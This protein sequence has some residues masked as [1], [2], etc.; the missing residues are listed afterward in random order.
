MTAA[1]F[2]SGLLTVDRE[3]PRL[4]FQE[5]A[6]VGK[7]PSRGEMGAQ[8][9]MLIEFHLDVCLAQEAVLIASD[10]PYAYRAERFSLDPAR[11]FPVFACR[12][13]LVFHFD[14]CHDTHRFVAYDE[15]DLFSRDNVV[16]GA[17]GRDAPRHWNLH[18]NHMTWQHL[19]KAP[20]KRLFPGVEQFSA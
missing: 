8:R 18:Q 14:R 16:I 12:L 19:H 6:L 1:G 11:R 10:E 17:G 9:R 20:V 13:R 5:G 15:V 2:N 7:T 3:K 4:A